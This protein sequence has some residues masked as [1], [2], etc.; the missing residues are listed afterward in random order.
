MMK[1]IGYHGTTYENALELAKGNYRALSERK[2]KWLGRGLYFFEDNLELAANYARAAAADGGEP[3]ILC[4]DI[5]LSHCL[6]VTRTYGQTHIR[7]AHRSL[8]EEWRS[9][10]EEGVKQE[11][12]LLHEGQVR[13]GFSGEW[14]GGNNKLDHVVI[15][16]AIEL[17]RL[18]K[19]FVF[20]TVRGI[21]LEEGPLFR[22]SWLFEGAHVAIAV[23]APAIRI[24][25][26]AVYRV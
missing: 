7:N 9:K 8:E 26:P 22:S 14:A 5:D 23:R 11:P 18:Q 24:T 21:F 17:A 13:A 1:R 19:D 10:G 20:D 12:F 25:N 16:R 2:G 3:G 4:A 15:E 6:D